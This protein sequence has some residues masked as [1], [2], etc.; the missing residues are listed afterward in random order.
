MGIQGRGSLGKAQAGTKH[1][2]GLVLL[3]CTPSATRE[4][5]SMPHPGKVV[6]AALLTILGLCI[7]TLVRS[8]L[9]PAPHMNAVCHWEDNSPITTAQL[10]RE[11]ESSSVP[12]HAKLSTVTL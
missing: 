7:L 2:C 3:Y 6:A 9:S 5:G 1:V 10:S 11:Q 12:S 4:P 8:C